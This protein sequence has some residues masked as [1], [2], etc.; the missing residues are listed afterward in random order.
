MVTEVLSRGTG[1]R[2]VTYGTERKLQYLLVN[3]MR[4]GTLAFG[5]YGDNKDNGYFVNFFVVQ[6]SL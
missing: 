5:V 2:M 3:F 1:T 6:G 4:R